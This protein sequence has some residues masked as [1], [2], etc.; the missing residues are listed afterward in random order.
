[1]HRP[2][3]STG[4]SNNHTCFYFQLA[5]NC[6]FDDL[7]VENGGSNSK[8]AV[9]DMVYPN[10]VYITTIS[11]NN[12]FGFQGIVQ[13]AAD[14]NSKIE[15][16]NLGLNTVCSTFEIARHDYDV[17]NEITT[18]HS[19]FGDILDVSTN[20]KLVKNWV[21]YWASQT[22]AT[23]SGNLSIESKG[24][25]EDR[26]DDGTYI[27]PIS[28]GIKLLKIADTSKY[29]NIKFLAHGKGA[30]M[31]LLLFDSSKNILTPAL[32]TCGAIEATL[33]QTTVLQK[34]GAASVNVP[35]I[36]TI[37]DS[38][39]AYVGVLFTNEFTDV[40]VYSDNAFDVSLT[41][42]ENLKYFKGKYVNSTKP[43]TPASMQGNVYIGQKVYD[44]NNL[45]TYWEL[46]A[47]D[48]TKVTPS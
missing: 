48:W 19:P 13:S 21:F 35:F 33:Y 1:M 45:G 37:L 39:V 46:G 8:F 34:G 42:Y 5:R 32:L 26:G 23:L 4:P 28:P 9:F 36:V 24:K 25:V 18:I 41:L 20:N 29:T 22:N 7:Y 30:Y 3:F 38:S 2:C 12:I 43:R 16:L 44:I 40:S 31:R 27:N 11:Y 17:L 10:G 15:F 47:N 14:H 6:R